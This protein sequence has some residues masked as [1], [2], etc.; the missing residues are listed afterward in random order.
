MQ[1]TL[2]SYKKYEN[3]ILERRLWRTKNFITNKMEKRTKKLT[4]IFSIIITIFTIGIVLKSFQNDTFFNISIGKYILENGIDMKEHF[5]WVDDDLD[6]TYSHWAFD[7]VIYLIYNSFDFTGIYVSVIIFSVIISVTL[8]NLLSKRSKSPIVSFLV[9]LMSIYIVKECFTARSQ[10]ISFL[11]FIIEIYC[12]EKF[13]ETNKKKYAII[14]IIQSIIIANFHAATWPLFLV[15]FMPYLGAAFLNLISSKNIYKMCI[16][17]LRRK[18]A[19]LPKDSPKIAIYEKDISDYER[20]IAERKSEYANYKVV[21]KENYNTKNLIILLIIVAFTG[22]LTPIHGT[23]YTY[24]IK[25]MFGPSNFENNASIDFILEMQ[26]ITPISNLA[27]LVF[28][29]ILIAFLTFLPSK[30]K[31]EH[32]FLLLGLIIMTLSSSRYVYLLVFLGSYALTDIITQSVNL[33]I[34]DDIDILERICSAPLGMLILVF[35]VCIFSTSKL[36]NTMDQEFVNESLYPIGAVEYIKEHLDY[37]NIRIYNSYNNGSYLM[38][39]DIPVFIDSRLDV[40]CSEFNNTDIF[41]DFIELS[42]GQIY[43]EDVFQKYDFTHI[44]LQDGDIVKNYIEHDT[45]YK[46]LYEDEYYSLYE[47]TIHE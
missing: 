23:P 29:M 16:K 10:I 4:I 38:L 5:C 11:C 41:Y 1:N 34:S 3:N 31:T 2:F 14:I 18:I 9:T 6:Y 19:K 21:R 28:S 7:I 30:I 35:L 17:R 27:I 26:P 42:N 40:Y 15:L 24:I 8:F 39:N 43:Y 12:I 20:I 47:R 25:S 32:G 37:R 44:L 46:V 22:L 33:L 45:N 36:L 13:I